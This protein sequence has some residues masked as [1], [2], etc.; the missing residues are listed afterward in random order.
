LKDRF[1]VALAAL[2]G[3]WLAGGCSAPAACTYDGWRERP[4]LQQSA[5]GTKDFDQTS[6]AETQALELKLTGLPE[7]WQ[8]S[9][10][11]FGST[12]ALRITTEYVGEPKGNDGNTQMPRVTA[13]LSLD[14]T[15]RTVTA[16]TSSFAM[17]SAESVELRLFEN[18]DE[19]S[20]EPGCCAWGSREC[21]V[22]LTLSAERLDGA[23]FPPVRVAWSVE[24]TAS[25]TACP[26]EKEQVQLT[27]SEVSR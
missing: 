17:G 1:S 11:V 13:R 7:L 6:S 16:S 22:P 10:N 19:E 5:S 25:A 26:L 18:C 27:L 9:Q 23:P 14:G 4:N 15:K 20:N 8:G 2:A 12:V 21:V 3:V 24:A